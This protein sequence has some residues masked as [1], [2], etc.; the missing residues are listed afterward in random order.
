MKFLTL[1]PLVAALASAAVLPV[2]EERAAQAATTCGSTYYS[3]NAV[4]SAAQKACS[5]SQAGSAP[6]G[7]PHT[8]N[9]YEGFSFS[10]SGPYLEF[11][12]LSSGSVYT[13][14]SPGA[15]RVVINTSCKLAGEITH[16]GASG[17]N[18]V[19]CSGTS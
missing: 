4:N 5:D 9:N 14:G 11:P 3:A 12:L 2:V 15:D 16:T 13:G 7:Y 8:Y 18:F 10:V 17:N 19:G 1:L 6:G